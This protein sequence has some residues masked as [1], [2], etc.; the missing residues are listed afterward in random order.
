MF[1]KGEVGIKSLRGRKEDAVEVIE[2]GGDRFLRRV[3]IR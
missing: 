3:G 2:H 1:F